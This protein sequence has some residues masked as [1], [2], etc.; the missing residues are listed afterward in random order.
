MRFLGGLTLF[1]YTL[2]F[3]SVGALFITISLDILSHEAIIESINAIY[4]APNARLILGITGSLLVVISLMVVQITVGKIQREKTIA[5]ENPYG[6]VTI[7]L[8]AIEDFI[9]RALKTLPEVKELR[10]QVRANKKGI[11]VI[12]RVTLFS[13]MNMPETTEKIQNI[14]K[15]RVQDM[16]GVE[17]PI[18]IKVHVVKIAHKEEPAKSA[19]KEDKPQPP[20]FRGSIEYGSY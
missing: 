11:T 18:N 12:N 7:S 19:K 14:V 10:P 3:L 17:E 9:K 13:D 15:T 20:T 4:A 8:S 16:L 6:Q 1:F 2:V 5:F